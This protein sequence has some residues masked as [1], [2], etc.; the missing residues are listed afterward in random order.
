[1]ID[2]ISHLHKGDFLA[3]FFFWICGT[4]LLG[5]I[6]KRL[7]DTSL[8]LGAKPLPAKPDPLEAAY[9]RDGREL[10][11]NL[12]HLDLLNR[13]K[14]TA[15]YAAEL[16]ALRHP[17]YTQ[18]LELATL[19]R[20][21]NIGDWKNSNREMDRLMAI[22]GGLEHRALQEQLLAAPAQKNSTRMVTIV[23]VALI[24]GM[25]ILKIY[26][27]IMQGFT[28]VGF[29][30]G[31]ILAGSIVALLLLRS[32]RLTRRGRRY[33]ADLKAAYSGQ[34]A[35][36]L[37]TQPAT[38][39]SAFDMPGPMLAAGIFGLGVLA[40]SP[41]STHYAAYYAPSDTGSGSCSSSSCGSSCSS[42]SSCGG[43]CGG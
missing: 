23:A 43:G 34:R 2:Y 9:L 37:K 38:D 25:G 24:A 16:E 26:I 22:P 13:E 8:Q 27:A 41:L 17:S 19:K 18:Q 33:L 39:Q 5:F 11:T 30:V 15:E 29:T 7:L 32:G 20:K 3:F 4:L 6:V 1:M 31:M 42:C 12:L 28:N 21:L 10:V 14:C 40:A 36:L 35:E